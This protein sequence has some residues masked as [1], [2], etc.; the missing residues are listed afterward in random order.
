MDQFDYFGDLDSLNELAYY[1]YQ[2]NQEN[3]FLTLIKKYGPDCFLIFLLALREHVKN[4]N[5]KDYSRL[6]KAMI[7]FNN[8]Y[9]PQRDDSDEL[10]HK[11]ANINMYFQEILNSS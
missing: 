6:K 1:W 8:W 5:E 9:T 10:F 3:G 2:E 4:I 11:I 7:A